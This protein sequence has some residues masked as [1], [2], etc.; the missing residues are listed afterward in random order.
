MAPMDTRVA[1]GCGAGEDGGTPLEVCARRPR[2]SAM[3]RSTTRQ[4]AA[5]LAL[6]EVGMGFAKVMWDVIHEKKNS[7]RA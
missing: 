4:Y 5:E 1:L 6:R 2:H 3:M 7:V